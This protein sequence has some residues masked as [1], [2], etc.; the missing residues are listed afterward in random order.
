[1]PDSSHLRDSLIYGPNWAVEPVRSWF[2]ESRRIACWLS[3][4]G[5]VAQAQADIGAIP[6]SAAD[7][8]VQACARGRLDLDAV[9]KLSHATG[10][11]TAGMLAAVRDLVGEEH[12]RYV[13]LS[14]TVQDIADTWTALSMKLTA[15]CLEADLRRLLGILRRDAQVHRDT[16]MLGRTHGQPGAPITFGFKQAQWGEELARSLRRLE[17]GRPRWETAQLGGS[18]GSLAYWGS[19]APALL[20]AFAHRVGLGV[21]V[22]P[23]MSARDCVAEFGLFAA[24]LGATLAKIGNEIY[25]LQRPEI[26]EIA[27]TATEA[28]IGSVTMPQKRNPERS[29]QLVTLGRLLRSYATMLLEGVVTEHER[30]GRSWK[31]EWVALSDLCCAVT[32]ASALGIELLDGLEVHIGR[33]LANAGGRGGLALSEQAVRLLEPSLGLPGAY[34]AVRHAAQATEA[35]QF[36][37]LSE[38]LADFAPDAQGLKRL[39]DPGSAV[40]SAATL[41]QAWIDAAC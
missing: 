11:S 37:H 7:H 18:V 22:L 23:W 4:L 1:M 33:M 25:Q 41:T 31:A 8:I 21:P 13:G 10:H 29:E 14:T 35:G 19:S 27:E 2:T 6:R 36:E 16:V 5:A 34:A 20:S 38:A 30:D 26:G 40:T 24:L 28:Q 3:I 39:R 15:E 9:A 32:R 17:E 12:A